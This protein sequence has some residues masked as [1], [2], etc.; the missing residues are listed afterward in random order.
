M[1]QTIRILFVV[2]LVFGMK[3]LSAQIKSLKG[4]LHLI[5]GIDDYTLEV[6]FISE[7]IYDSKNAKIEGKF[8]PEEMGK[9]K[10]MLDST[11]LKF[12][13]LISDELSRIT[14]SKS[15][16]Q[17][18]N[19]ST[20]LDGFS[21]LVK[22]ETSQYNKYDLLELG[23]FLESLPVVEYADLVPKDFCPPP[24]TINDGTLNKVH[25]ITPSLSAYQHYLEA[26]PGINASYAWGL[27]TFGQDI[28]VVDIEYD[29]DELHEDI[30][31][32]FS[33]NFLPVQPEYEDHGTAVLGVMTGSLNDF[34][35]TGGAH[36]ASYR[37]YGESYGRAAA[38]LTAAEWLR[39][40]DIML[41]EMQTFATNGQFGPA[42]LTLSVWDAV[43]AATTKGIHVVA[44][45]GNGAV[46]LDTEI[47]YMNRGDNGSVIV[48]AGSNTIE[49]YILGFST[50]G[51]RVNLQGWG[52]N[53]FTSGY[54]DYA[55][56]E[57]D[58]HR[59]YT[60][61]FSGTSSASAIVATAIILVQSWALN[62]LDI[63]IPPRDMR[64]LLIDTGQPQLNFPFPGVI[65]SIYQIGPIPNVEAAVNKLLEYPLVTVNEPMT[66]IQ[67]EASSITANE[68]YIVDNTASNVELICTITT[69][70]IN[71]YL[72]HK[73]I[74]GV[75]LSFFSQE[76]I[77]KSDIIYI[78]NGSETLS[79]NFTFSISDGDNQFTNQVFDIE[80]VPKDNNFPYIVNNK[81]LLL[82][83]GTSAIIDSTLLKVEDIEVGSQLISFHITDSLHHGYIAHLD[84]P[85][86]PIYQWTQNSIENNRIIYQHDGSNSITDNM[87]LSINDSTNT[88]S[89]IG[90]EI[91]INPINDDEPLL[92]RN[93][94]AT[95]NE[96]GFVS[97]TEDLLSASDY[98][99][100]EDE[101]V[102]V[103]TA[104]SFFGHLEKIDSK[105]IP[106]NRFTQT[107]II[108]ESIV[109]SP[110]STSFEIDS[111]QFELF[112]GENYSIRYE[113]KIKN[114]I[115]TN[116]LEVGK[117]QIEFYPNPVQN[118]LLV[119]SDK[120]ILEIIISDINGRP[121][122]VE[123]INAKEFRLSTKKLKPSI[124][125]ISFRTDN[126]I[127]VKKII[128]NPEIN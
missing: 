66:V 55:E 42:D 94:I 59:Q 7:W 114:N 41:L 76:N 39:P 90:F 73:D 63:V 36:E 56:Y 65:D 119:T 117:Y 108:K 34:G 88:L 58:E 85:R 84:N 126:N 1:S 105:G 74:P 93:E 13:P 2:L 75:E 19:M 77:I 21:G 113:F 69:K 98:D 125:Y 43:L 80:I 92:I 95:L 5:E 8:S 15:E 49:H 54:G 99:T 46:D 28:R 91:I 127:Y 83:E 4:G 122:I 60:G 48:G 62:E 52:Q 112:D 97:I 26:D 100:P 107:D 45:A 37:G 31:E 67:G 101:I 96:E 89:D 6:K 115:I 68:L 86:E 23:K 24:V 121:I 27:G 109:F 124:Y 11:G 17:G 71:G 64:K 82:N 3:P 32:S 29:W 72:E 120:R 30:P 118:D 47:T 57:N 81:Q 25:S 123:R 38:I 40:G 87:I 16:R 18:T 70:P 111:F 79:D 12:K 35:I 61:F 102:F 128:K 10:K 22:I 44:A 103:V 78:H 14:K 116:L 104:P 33:D 51:S 50:Y 110:T 106:I 9:Y 20:I 53:V